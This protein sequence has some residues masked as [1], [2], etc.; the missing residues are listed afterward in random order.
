MNDW[1]ATRFLTLYI[2]PI[3]LAIPLWLRERL[4]VLELLTPANRMVDAAVLAV[5]AARFF[6]AVVP[7]S[8]H[9]LFL[10]YSA[11]TTPNRWYQL[12]AV[13]LIIETTIF[14]LGVWGDPTTW[15]LGAAAGLVAGGLYRL[16][17]LGPQ[18]T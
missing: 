2:A 14:K 13:A 16:G 8:G 10:V 3:L 18:A 1:P 9:M 4:R 7:V 5:A 15:G 17:R 12:L 6:G 11:V